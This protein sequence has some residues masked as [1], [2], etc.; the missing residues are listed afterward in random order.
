MRLSQK[1]LADYLGV[2]RASLSGATG[3]GHKCQGYPV[4][5]WAIF[6][7]SGRVAGYDVPQR[8]MDRPSPSSA[9]SEIDPEGA[10]GDAEGLTE[11]ISGGK[12]G[13]FNPS[14]GGDNDSGEMGW[15]EA[16]AETVPKVTGQTSTA[17]VAYRY[18]DVV[19]KHPGLATD[20]FDLMAGLGMAGVG[21]SA[22]NEGDS[23]RWWKVLVSGLAGFAGMRMARNAMDRETTPRIERTQRKEMPS[24]RTDG[25]VE[26]EK[27]GQTPNTQKSRRT[28]V[29]VGGSR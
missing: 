11:L 4:R 10:L 22:T 1:E 18:A 14:G 25:Q 21:L 16:T 15:P 17:A 26:G 6:D 19:E 2:T 5:A 28:G 3:E 8:V 9:G 7:A 13:R 27:N 24:G 12:P 29:T 23:S 20:L